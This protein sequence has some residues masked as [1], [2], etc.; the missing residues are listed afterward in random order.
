MAHIYWNIQS[1]SE[2]LIVVNFRPLAWHWQN[3]NKKNLESF[4]NVPKA[5]K[6]MVAGEIKLHTAGIAELNQPTNQSTD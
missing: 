6:D 4:L 2:A 1:K 5:A 3:Q